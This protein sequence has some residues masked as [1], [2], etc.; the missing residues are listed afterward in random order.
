MVAQPA[1]EYQSYFY[2]MLIMD[3]GSGEETRY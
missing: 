1:G 3:E 2:V